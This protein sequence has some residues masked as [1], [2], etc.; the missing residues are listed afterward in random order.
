MAKG[1]ICHATHLNSQHRLKWSPLASNHKVL[2]VIQNHLLQIKVQIVLFAPN[3]ILSP[4]LIRNTAMLICE[5][6]DTMIS[7]V[8]LGISQY[9]GKFTLAPFTTTGAV[10]SL[11]IM[12]FRGFNFFHFGFEDRIVPVPG[13]SLRKHAHVIY[14]NIS[15]L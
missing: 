7:I 13:Q 10:C 6:K 2:C 3:K 8:K 1:V 15:R 11:C 12:Y 14:N 4:F 9:W 5:M